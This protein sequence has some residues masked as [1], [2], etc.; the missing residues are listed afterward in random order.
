VI[1]YIDRQTMAVLAPTLQHEFHLSNV[2]YAGIASA[3]LF[4]YSLSMWAWGAVFNR[5]G[6]RLGFAL[7]IALW[8]LA[9]VGHAAARGLGSF[10]AMRFL[11]GAGESGN[12][13]GVT[14]SIAAWFPR[15]QRALA[16]GIAN[17]GAA[18]GGAAAPPLIIAVQLRLGW[19]AAFVLTGA[20]GFLWILAWLAVYPRGPRTT[21]VAAAAAPPVPWTQ[22]LRRRE[23][24]GIILGRFFGD[25]IW[26][27]YLNWLP[28]YLHNARGFT[29][30][31][32]RA[33]AWVPYLAA[34]VG[35][36]LGGACS[37]FLINRGRSVNFARKTAILIGTVL[38]P[39]GMAAAWVDSPYQA[40]AC[41]SVTLFGFQ[42]W[43]G[44]VQTL[45]SDLFPVSAVGSIA[46]FAGSAAGIG[47]IILTQSTGWVVDHFSYT[48]ILVAAGILA[49]VATVVL[50]VLVGRIARR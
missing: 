9:A 45:P 36:L 10:R 50:F 6:N 35:C 28:L 7:A 39:A 12:W 37:G 30:K 14:R 22:L 20:L 47:A 2:Q 48:P 31:E 17:A 46:G 3:F 23:V 15:D 43:V 42:F 21:I 33:S 5:L 38:M 29:I 49:P 11:L 44:N 4:T 8:S 40:L 41:I 34:G 24:W 18:L 32:I 13:P 19:R 25:P 1:N 26:W 27:L 16:M